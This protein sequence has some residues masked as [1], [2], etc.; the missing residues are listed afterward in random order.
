V[1]AE[2]FTLEQGKVSGVL[3]TNQGYAVVALTETKPSYVPKVEEV[4]DKVKDDVIRA[5]A[6]EL[7]RAKAETMATGGETNFAAAA[8]AAGVDVRTTDF[9][10]RGSARAGSGCERIAW[11]RRSSR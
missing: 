6:V 7:A 2:A 3:R 10:S 9:I 4:R 8:T 11:T 1:T 5:K